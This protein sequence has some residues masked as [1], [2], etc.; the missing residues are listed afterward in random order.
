[1]FVKFQPMRRSYWTS[2][3]V[4]Q[5]FID[6]FCNEHGYRFVPSSSV[7]A[8]IESNLMFTNAGMNQ[9]RKIFLGEPTDLRCVVNSQKCI[10]VSGKH[11]DLADVGHDGTHH[12]FFEMLGHWSFNGSV[13]KFQ[14]SQQAWN[15]LTEV[16]RIPRD[17][18]FVTYFGGDESNLPADDEAK[19]IWQDIGLNASSIISKG[20]ADNFWEMGTT[21]PC[22]PCTEIH[23]VYGSSIEENRELWN[24]VFIQNDR[25]AGGSLKS[26]PNFHVDTGMG[27]ERLV[28]ILQNKNSNYATDL[29][30][31]IMEVIT[32]ELNIPPYEDRYGDDCSARDIM[33]RIVSDHMRMAC[34]AISDGVVPGDR[35]HGFIVRKL[36]RLAAYQAFKFNARPELFR[37]LTQAVCAS[38][39][40]AYPNLIE[41]QSAIEK[42]IFEQVDYFKRLLRQGR[43]DFKNMIVH[44]GT[45]VSVNQLFQLYRKGLPYELLQQLANDNGIAFNHADLETLIQ[46]E[47][48]SS[49]INDVKISTRT[50]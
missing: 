46:Q 34:V 47:K 43:R 23:Y 26:L 2:A 27:L 38:L 49:A 42:T 17:R 10:R 11:N 40:V 39:G 28:A 7:V 9:F 12:T 14:A 24:L 20:I 4:R 16:F 19:R 37:H 1:M 21:G 41:K 35:G 8:P 29:F 50:T 36:I 48:N 18:L 33:Y 45:A 6:Y 22:G 25:L 5:T 44:R 30:Q 3:K 13:S 32:K 15:L 31:P